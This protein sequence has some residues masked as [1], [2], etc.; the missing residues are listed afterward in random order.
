MIG[1]NRTTQGWM[2]LAQIAI[3]LPLVG[4]ASHWTLAIVGLCLLWRLGIF[5]ARWSRPPRWLLNVLGIGAAIALLS[6]VLSTGTMITL[7][8]LLL[9]GYSLKSIEARDGKDL[10]VVVLTGYFLIGLHLLDRFGPEMGL[11]LLLMVALNSA[12]MISNYRLQPPKQT[13]LL[14]LK[15]VVASLP[16]A[17]VLFALI[18]R[19][20]PM[21]QIQN[22][23]IARTGLADSMALG[24]IAQ[25]TRSDELVMRA[26]FDEPVPPPAQLYWRAL[27]LDHYDGQRW[28]SQADTSFQPRFAA[29]PLPPYRH[30]ELHVEA[31]NQRWLAVLAGSVSNSNKVQPQPEQRLGWVTPLASRTRL[32]LQQGQ[33]PALPQLTAAARRK[34]LQL[35]ASGNDQARQ[36]ATQLAAQHPNSGERLQA[37]LRHF[38]QQPFR[39]TLKP[40]PLGRDQIDDFLFTNQAGFCGH[41]ASATVFL[42][43]ASGIPARVVTGYQGGE[44]N[45]SNR[46]VSV[47][48]YNAHA[49]VEYW[50]ADQGWVR[51]DPTAA[52][53]PERVEQGAEAAFGDQ[54]EFLAGGGLFTWR[55]NKLLW[56]LRGM[57]AQLDYHWSRYIIGFDNDRQ[58]QLWQR[59]LGG[60]Q[61][62]KVATILAI[63]LLLVGLTQSGL[64]QRQPRP[65]KAVRL[66]QS[67]QQRLQRWQLQRQPHEAPLAHLQRLERHSAQLHQLYQ[68]L[69]HAFIQLQ[70]D[71]HHTHAQ[72]AQLQQHHR[73]FMA[74]SRL[75]SAPELPAA[76]AAESSPAR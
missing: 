73:H 3:I 75:L 21:W 52:V 5:Y 56:Q 9:L 55:N 30:Y 6:Q 7:I 31:N 41:Y 57:M 23:S 24:D 63:T 50:Q 59:W 60:F 39:Y 32:T 58:L 53:A 20:P 33:L 67:A 42:A 2:L 47:Y 51:L 36:W 13:L 43:R 37:L 61:W 25:L 19:L 48:Q 65:S 10:M 76:T 66:Y 1:I 44:L 14:S 18:P 54:A 12:S 8:N 35:P 22:S 64:L 70:Y 71:P 34:N 38:R 45:A 27:V 15:V 29:T 28:R 74:K 69:C 46:F 62:W 16:L 26:S 72:L 17:L 68:P 4:Q 40:P 49:W 11:Q